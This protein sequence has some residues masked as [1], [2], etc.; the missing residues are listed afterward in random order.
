MDTLKIEF[1]LNWT[2]KQSIDRAHNNMV[3]A[4]IYYSTAV[5]E[6]ANYNRSPAAYLNNPAEERAKSVT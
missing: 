4:H 5:L 1:D 3:P 6:D 2:I